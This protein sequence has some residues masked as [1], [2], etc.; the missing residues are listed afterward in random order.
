MPGGIRKISQVDT[1]DFYG[2]T[3]Q[4][5]GL[6]MS[7]FVTGCLWSILS[8]FIAE[9]TGFAYAQASVKITRGVGVYRL[10]DDG[11]V[12]KPRGRSKTQPG[13]RTESE[14]SWKG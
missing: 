4:A 14:L 6:Q 13:S 3:T 1:L 5:G 8:T 11:P 2:V 12:G 7:S 9:L 10:V